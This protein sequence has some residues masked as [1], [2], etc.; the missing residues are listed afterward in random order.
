MGL[1]VHWDLPQARLAHALRKVAA[2][3]WLLAVR[4]IGK[5]RQW[6]AQHECNPSQT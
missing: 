2:A 3:I 4:P 6:H 1:E 5:Y